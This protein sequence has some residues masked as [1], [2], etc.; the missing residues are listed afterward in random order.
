MWPNQTEAAECDYALAFCFALRLM[1]EESA[2]M[3]ERAREDLTLDLQSLHQPIDA[4][5][6]YA[7]CSP[8]MLMRKSIQALIRV[9]LFASNLRENREMGR[10]MR[11]WDIL[12]Q[13]ATVSV[14]TFTSIPFHL[15][16]DVPLPFSP[17]AAINF[18]SCHLA[19]MTTA[20]FLEDGEW[21]GFY[22]VPYRR[23]N[24]PSFDPPMHGIHFVVTAN[25]NGQGTL[26][27]QS[28]GEDAVGAFD[29]EGKLAPGTGH[30][31]MKK[32]YSGGSP[33]WDWVC[34]MTPVGIVG[35]WGG[36]GTYG[37]GIWLWKTGWTT[38][39]HA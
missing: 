12:P 26:N 38:D 31:S 11:P 24:S 27:L 16:M 10:I 23:G 14:P 34:I 29:L 33:V 18:A 17:N 37:G 36:G 39:H 22:S 13:T 35:E 1:S 28:T 25:T 32:T 5:D 2:S 3:A 15:M 21:A 30:I 19:K 4:Y 8:G 7:A 20:D 9:G 6:F